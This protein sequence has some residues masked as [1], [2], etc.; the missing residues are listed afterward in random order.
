[1]SQT[2]PQATPLLSV[3]SQAPPAPPPRPPAVQKPSSH[4]WVALC[5]PPPWGLSCL[6]ALQHVLVL[7]SLLCAS[8]LLLLRSLPPEG[9]SYP[10]A[11]LL[12]SSLFSC[13]MSTTLQTWMG[14]SLSRA[15]PV[16]GAWLPRPG[17]L[18][19]F[20]PRGVWG[21]GGVRAAAGHA[22]AAGGSWPLVLPL[23]AP[24]A[25]PQPGC[26]RALCPQ[27][28][29]PVLFHSLGPG[30]AAYPA[31]G[32]L[33]PAPGLLPVTPT[34]LEASC[35]LFNPHSHRCLQG[36]L[37]ADP[38]GLCVDHLCPS[39]AQHHPPGAVCPHRGTVVLAASPR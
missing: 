19:Y 13:G 17:A 33:F 8:H 34:P 36:P 21:C 22:G 35:D 10:P 6:L 25:G 37:G 1:M 29:G 39:G 16:Q 26:G 5:G 9:L 20:S 14:S 38:S 2:P 32:G 27:G 31:R 12:A 4:S 3:G 28:G 23:W 18:E 24:G 30:M 11:Q 7:A 15:E